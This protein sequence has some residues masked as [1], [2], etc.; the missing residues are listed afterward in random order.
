MCWRDLISARST[1]D[2]ITLGTVLFE[3]GRRE[4]RHRLAI[5]GVTKKNSWM[6]LDQVNLVDCCTHLQQI[7]HLKAI[8]PLDVPQTLPGNSLTI[9]PWLMGIGRGLAG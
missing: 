8:G 2:A 1:T 4:I 7:D 5:L 9:P 3:C 6:A